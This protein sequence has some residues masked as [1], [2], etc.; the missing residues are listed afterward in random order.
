MKLYPFH[1][2]FQ[3]NACGALRNLAANGE[4]SKVFVLF[5][6]SPQLTMSVS[7]FLSFFG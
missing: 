4:F 5:F 1:F 3:E 7:F 2:A 6:L